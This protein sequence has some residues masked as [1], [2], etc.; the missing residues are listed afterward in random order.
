[1][2]VGDRE[3]RRTVQRLRAG[4]LRGELSDETFERRLSTALA[5][6][7]FDELQSVAADL[8]RWGDR[9]RM[10]IATLLSGSDADAPALVPPA[11]EPGEALTLG[12]S[13]DADVRFAERSVSR[14]HA[15]LRRLPG[16]WLLVDRASTNGT[17][18]NGARVDR[19]RVGDGDEICL[20]GAA[21]VVLRA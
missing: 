5:A 9:L 3:R 14:Q 10:A 4:Y 20:G 6:R 2:R 12:R 18:V 19:A 7:W 16:G 1:V 8:P 11:L 21:R 17:W 13:L 15:E